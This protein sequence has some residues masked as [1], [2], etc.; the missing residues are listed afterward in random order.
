MLGSLIVGSLLLWQQGLQLPKSHLKLPP[1]L[2]AEFRI[3]DKLSSDTSY[4]LKVTAEYIEGGYCDDDY[5]ICCEN[6]CKGHIHEDHKQCDLSCDEPCDA[7]DHEHY[8]YFTPDNDDYAQKNESIQRLQSIG[9]GFCPSDSADQLAYHAL[10]VSEW[11]IW[12]DKDFYTEQVVPCWNKKPCTDS[13]RGYAA[14]HVTIRITY[15]FYKEISGMRAAGPTGKLDYATFVVPDFNDPFEEDY[16]MCACALTS[17]L[18]GSK[19]RYK[20]GDDFGGIRLGDMPFAPLVPYNKLD[21]YG[22]KVTCDDMNSAT[23]T[24]HNPTGMPLVINMLPG[25]K[26]VSGDPAAQNMLI[27][28][29]TRLEIPA[30]STASV[31]VPLGENPLPVTDDPTATGGAVCIN[32]KRHEPTAET[33][34]HAAP[35]AGGVLQRLANFASKE[36]IIGPWVQTRFWIATDHATLD[37]VQKVLRQKPT[38]GHYL[39]AL[40]EVATVGRVDMMREPYKRCMEPRMIVGA[41][42]TSRVTDWFVDTFAKKD[43]KTLANWVKQN[44][45]A[46]APL[47]A[48]DALDFAIR[49]AADVANALCASQDPD[50]RSAGF[51]FMLNVIPEEK[52]ATFIRSNG[53][54]GLTDA[55]MDG[56]EKTIGDA[57]AVAEAYKNRGVGFGLVNLSPKASAEQKERAKN[58]MKSLKG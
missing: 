26:L 39:R 51:D 33:K 36:R 21:S 44:H 18:D 9:N 53:L 37:E 2:N 16:T 1:P 27:T 47:F 35:S 15:S 32:M 12:L 31:Q 24:S 41:S 13:E 48:P 38:E 8:L 29:R 46:F 49:H 43:P 6:Y 56:D 20:T 52:R 22:F 25:T 4:Y 17:I 58:L 3:D 30:W 14:R 7:Y 23:I 34:F 10:R 42:A 11:P 50:L 45:D 28:K 19:V 40:Y 55:L 57:L 54:F 5:Y